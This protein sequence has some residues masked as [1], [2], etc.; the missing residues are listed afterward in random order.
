MKSIVRAA[1]VAGLL[2]SATFALAPVAASAADTPKLTRE[3][4][5]D[6][7]GAQKAMQSNDYATALSNVQKAQGVSD[8]TPY[9][10]YMI[11]TFLAEI[12]I[13]QKDYANATAPMEAAADSPAIPDDQKK[14]TYFNAFQLAMNAKHYQKAT[15]Y[16]AN[17]AAINALDANG[18]AMLA[19]AY[20]ETQDFP[21]AE[22]Y[23]QKSVDMAKAAGQTPNQGALV[24]IFNSQV[25]Q[26][27]N[28]AA[29][30]TM[31]D[32]AV[33]SNDAADW[34]QLIDQALGGK[35]VRDEDAFYLLRLKMLI[36]GAMTGE[37][38]TVLA[39]AADSRG[40]A[41]EAYNVLQKGIAAGKTTAAKAGPLYG[42]AKS[43][44]AM[45]QQQLPQIAAAAA[46]S[47][48]GQQDIKLAEDYWGYGRYADVEAAAR[49]AISKGGLKTP[50]E[51]PMVL[52]MALVAEGK[53][54][55]AIQTLSQSSGAAA[56]LWTLYA[57]AQLKKSGSTAQA[58]AP[59]H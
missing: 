57:K 34:S 41:T 54:D 3:V 45:D 9:D 20:Y 12:Y 7:A 40:Y 19:E 24:I 48:T 25:K 35:N 4:Q 51:G 8:R 38:Y 53:Y 11:N 37:D 15:T 31:E 6:L 1:F 26:H 21:H 13:G 36:P 16:G 32:M 27:N 22:Q 46:K 14:Q 55:E 43:G 30:Q 17:L 42:H 47:K 18:Y 50:T 5:N 52:G 29:T 49:R 58:P 23:A 33:A 10:D 28:G 59:A 56:H 44:A 39:S 2:S